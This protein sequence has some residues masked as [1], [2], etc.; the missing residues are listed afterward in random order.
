MTLEEE[1]RLLEAYSR[2]EAGEW[3]ED[4]LGEMPDYPD[5]RLVRWNAQDAIEEIVGKAAI[6]R[7]HHVHNLKTTKEEWLRWYTVDKFRYGVVS[8]YRYKNAG[9]SPVSIGAI[10]VL[11]AITIVLG[12]LSSS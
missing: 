11:A 9:V 6:S 5:K 7:Y 10:V 1:N 12:V 2:L 4:V 3:P 8:K